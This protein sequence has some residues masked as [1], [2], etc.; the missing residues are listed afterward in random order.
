MERKR[1]KYGAYTNPWDG[2][3]IPNSSLLS[4]EAKPRKDAER[5]TKTVWVN[6]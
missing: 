2:S 3:I 6:A 4:R 5:G 1:V